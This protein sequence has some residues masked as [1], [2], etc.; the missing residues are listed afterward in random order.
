[1]T[2]RK[3]TAS[4]EG[5][6]GGVPLALL[7]L[8]HLGFAILFL[9]PDLARGEAFAAALSHP[10]FWSALGLSLIIAVVSTA[11]ALMLAT[12]IIMGGASSKLLGAYLAIPHLAFAVGLSFLLQPSGL[13]ARLI[14]FSL[15]WETPPQITTIQDPWGLALILAL[16]LKEIPFL[17]W[18]Y[19]AVLQSDD[20]AQAL[21]AQR[22]AAASLG[23]GE[24]SIWT[25]IILPQIL[26]QITWPLIA[27][28]IYGATV[29]DMAL[30]LGPTLPPTLGTIIWR[31]INDVD[32]VTNQRGAAAAILLTA[33]LLVVLGVIEALRHLVR[34][35]LRTHFARGPSPG[36]TSAVLSRGILQSLLWIY[37]SV[38]FVLVALSVVGQWPFPAI[39]PHSFSVRSWATLFANPAPVLTS[40]TLAIAATVSAI[41]A[42]LAWFE[43]QPRSRDKYAFVASGLVLCLPAI[44]LAIG[45][46][47]VLLHS[48]LAGTATGL[49]LVHVLPVLAY[50]FIL[51][52]GPWRAFDPRYATIGQGLAA[53]RWRFF[54]Q[55][56][57][58][59]LK[60]PVASTMA[61]GF[62]VSIAQ[63]VP[64][65][66][67]ASGRYSTLP[68]EAVTLASGTNRPLLAAF[69]FALA[70]LP[71]LAFVF[72]QRVARPRWSRA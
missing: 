59:L 26:P 62:A 24:G 54:W 65:Q 13:L 11:L 67:A 53:S 4:L 49:Y 29:V 37:V 68:M 7:L 64:A 41:A 22:R 17:L 57:L 2:S 56:K 25:R 30:I 45:Q 40:L 12:V 60:A 23:H 42:A 33:S 34:P 19:G 63:F 28:F 71:L 39:L 61:V 9:L 21:A 32:L 47:R 5:L 69:A 18:A 10:Q 43:S 8:C 27:V 51:L 35:L 6:V 50:V 70:A 52:R 58:P 14:A 15:G 16:A 20:V 36:G 72:A 1:M 55:V 38:A 66:L 44:L 46:Y 31:D 48:N 3:L